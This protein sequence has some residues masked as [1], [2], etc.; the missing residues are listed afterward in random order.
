MHRDNV[1]SRVR[2]RARLHGRNE[3]HRAVRAVLAVLASVAPPEAFRAL[4]AALPAELLPSSPWTG[5]AATSRQF[6]AGVAGCLYLDE[7][8]AAF[9]CR[10]VF[11]ELNAALPASGPTRIAAGLP[12]DLRPLLT[13]RPPADDH[14]RRML[15]VRGL[16]APSLRMAGAPLGDRL[17]DPLGD[18][19]S[20]GTG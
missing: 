6:V 3:T 12:A 18:S 1:V 16:A 20:V 13:A 2:V 8:S 7:P 9:L 15:S 4:T 5:A 17:G 10:V 19:I 11:E 14:H